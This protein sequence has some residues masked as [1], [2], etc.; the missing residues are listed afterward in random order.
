MSQLT[1]FGGQVDKY[2][3][4]N[5]VH[6]KILFVLTALFA[7]NLYL[8]YILLLRGTTAVKVQKI[9]T[10]GIVLTSRLS[11]HQVSL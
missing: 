10:N 8:H 9:S 6:N 2:H 11:L 7:K 4:S 3:C 1:L 5:K